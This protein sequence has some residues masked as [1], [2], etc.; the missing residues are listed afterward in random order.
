MAIILESRAW[1][2]SSRASANDAGLAH[3]ESHRYQVIE[4]IVRV[5]GLFGL[6]WGVIVANSDQLGLPA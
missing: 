4:V 3:G 1:N 2:E 6:Q 5:K